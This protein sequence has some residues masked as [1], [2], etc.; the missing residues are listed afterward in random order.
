MLMCAGREGTVTTQTHQ[1]YG[2]P[3][4]PPSPRGHGPVSLVRKLICPRTSWEVPSW[5]PLGSFAVARM[6]L[7]LAMPVARCTWRWETPIS[8]AGTLPKGDTCPWGGIT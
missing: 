5:K 3:Q 2:D 7:L 1:H 4:S 6:C 8:R